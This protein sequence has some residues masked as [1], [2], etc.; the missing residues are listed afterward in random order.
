V[1]GVPTNDD[2]CR[3]AAMNRALD[4]PAAWDEGRSVQLSRVTAALRDEVVA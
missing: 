1:G 3:T 4:E 2:L